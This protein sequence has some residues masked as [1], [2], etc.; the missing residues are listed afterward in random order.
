MWSFNSTPS[1]STTPTT[2]SSMNSSIK[3]SGEELVKENSAD[4]RHKSDTNKGKGQTMNDDDEEISLSDLI[5]Q[6]TKYLSNQIKAT[7]VELEQKIDN[8]KSDFSNKVNQLEKV[9]NKLEK[10]LAHAKKEIENLTKK[11]NDHN[12]VM[13]G[14]PYNEAE[15]NETLFQ[16]VQQI[17]ENQLSLNVNVDVAHR[18]SN[19]N[20]PVIVKMV[21]LREKELIL[22]NCY[23]L[24]GT[25]LAIS[26]DLPKR[27]RIVNSII[28]SEMKAATEQKKTCK[29][30]G[31]KLLIDNQLSE[32]IEG[33]FQKSK[34][35]FLKSPPSSNKINSQ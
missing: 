16:E 33:K 8:M 25:T 2:I 27:I 10:E 4:K 29:R 20:G 5:K 26:E 12:L 28:R 3:R 1:S 30:V 31:E 11:V 9:N 6:Q 34:T 13:H 7:Q 17:I 14:I 22:R 15:T 24:K 18:I 21:L 35:Q 23:K 19:G 32:I